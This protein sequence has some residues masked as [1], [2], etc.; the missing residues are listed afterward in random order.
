VLF[1]LPAHANAPAGRFAIASGTVYDTKT[2]LT[3][4]QSQALN[5]SAGYEWMDARAYCAA[6]TLPGT[7]WRL[8]TVKELQTIV[9]PS[10]SNP[11]ID[12]VAFPA[13]S[14]VFFWSSSPLAGSSVQM[15]MVDFK[16][17]AINKTYV[18]NA[19]AVRCVR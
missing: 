10:L 6:L 17:G 14:S 7:G 4:Q 12:P 19:A 16:V 2:K 1:S 15:W 18:T 13:T 9:D 5:G 3:W 11:A 8:P